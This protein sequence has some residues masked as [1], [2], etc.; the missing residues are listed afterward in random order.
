MVIGNLGGKLTQVTVMF[1]VTN[2]EENKK[3]KHPQTHEE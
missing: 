2:I 3:Q 1:T